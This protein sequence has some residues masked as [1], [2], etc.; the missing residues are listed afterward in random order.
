[1]F[2]CLHLIYNH[3]LDPKLIIPGEACKGRPTIAEAIVDLVYHLQEELLEFIIGLTRPLPH[4]LLG[5]IH[6]NPSIVSGEMDMVVHPGNL[7]AFGGL[8]GEG[9][10]KRHCGYW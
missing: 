7:V 6:P 9:R 2:V 5:G 4:L 3:C 1:M 8:V 10:D